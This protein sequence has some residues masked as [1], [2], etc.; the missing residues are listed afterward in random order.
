MELTWHVPN[1]AWCETTG[2]LLGRMEEHD[3]IH[4]FP[5]VHYESINVQQHTKQRQQGWVRHKK[6]VVLN[7]LREYSLRCSCISILECFTSV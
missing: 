4:L 7:L 6:P 2:T 5:R 3:Q 1:M